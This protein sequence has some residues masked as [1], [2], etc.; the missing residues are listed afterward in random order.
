MGQ[1]LSNCE[2]TLC[3]AERVQS[4]QT[5]SHKSLAHIEAAKDEAIFK[6]L[7]KSLGLSQFSFPEIED[8]LKT[9]TKFGALTK[10]QA[11]DALRRAG[12][13]KSKEAYEIFNKFLITFEKTQGNMRIIILNKL[14]TSI[15]LLTKDSQQ[16]KINHL[17][18]VYAVGG[19]QGGVVK[20]VNVRQILD[21]LCFT[22][23]YA[24]PNLAYH[25]CIPGFGATT[26]KCQRV[27]DVKL[28]MQ[29]K[30]YNDKQNLFK[31]IMGQHQVLN[32]EEFKLAMFST[33]LQ[34]I[35][36]TQEL[37]RRLNLES[38]NISEKQDSFPETQN[39]QFQSPLLGGMYL[40]QNNL[41]FQDKL[42]RRVK[43]ADQQNASN[44]DET[45]EPSN[46]QSKKIVSSSSTPEIQGYSQT[47]EQAN[48]LNNLIA[49]SRKKLYNQ[50][51]A[52][53]PLALK[54]NS[55]ASA[56]TPNESLDMT[57][58]IYIGVLKSK[59]TREDAD[60]SMYSNNNEST[61]V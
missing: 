2:V 31:V 42:K 1:V 10:P 60:Y 30:V 35:L 45:E 18:G 19:S 33:Y 61:M 52:K 47:L 56:I 34:G 32:A 54:K 3:D 20:R 38:P 7:E 28:D 49:I 8:Q 17:F 16:D 13:I 59:L 25:A 11:L 36:S 9:Q 26:Q 39:S 44:S 22:V 48:E 12:V 5:K 21:H 29:K 4:S 41:L 51:K 6:E 53:H 57:T 43:F 24:I 14:L 23:I 37:R 15:L 46:Q 50:S 55:S 58:Q 27:M 40:G